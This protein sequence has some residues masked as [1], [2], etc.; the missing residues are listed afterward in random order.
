MRRAH[1]QVALYFL[2]FPGDTRKWGNSIVENH[3]RMRKNRLSLGLRWGFK[4]LAGLMD[5]TININRK[6]Q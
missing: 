1:F 2:G 5:T 4:K 3:L 6:V